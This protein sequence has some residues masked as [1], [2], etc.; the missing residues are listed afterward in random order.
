[1]SISVGSQTASS[2]GN[3]WIITTLTRAKAFGEEPKRLESYI[4]R[5]RPQQMSFRITLIDS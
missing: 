4:C 3:C 5:I 1:M 2:E